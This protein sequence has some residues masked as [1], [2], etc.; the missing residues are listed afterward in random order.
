MINCAKSSFVSTVGA[1]SNK[2]E[3]K[4]KK[5]TESKYI[6]PTVSGTSALH[7]IL[8]SLDIDHNH[9]VI[10]PS[11]TFVGTANAIKYCGAEPN[12]VDVSKKTF[13]IDPIKLEEYLKKNCKIRNNVCFNK[14][15]KKKK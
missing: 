7:A 8:F 13:G 6:I 14:K 9:E 15:T 10:V 4:L 12:F 3:K 5:I 11:L 2:F 1:Y